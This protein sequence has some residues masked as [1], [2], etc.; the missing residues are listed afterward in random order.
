[1][2]IHWKIQFLGKC[3]ENQYIGGELPKRADWIV[4]TFKEGLYLKEGG[5][6]R[7]QCTIWVGGAFLLIEI[8]RAKNIMWY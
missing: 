1:M 4:C 7:P 3:L 6:V 5:S 8:S 2:K